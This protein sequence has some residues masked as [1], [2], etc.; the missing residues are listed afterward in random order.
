VILS[1]CD[2]KTLKRRKN[3]NGLKKE[4]LEQFDPLETSSLSLIKKVMS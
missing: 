3:A 2:L 4:I 1:L